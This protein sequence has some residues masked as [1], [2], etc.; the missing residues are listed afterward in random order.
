MMFSRYSFYD[1]SLQRSPEIDN[2][3]IF[4]PKRDHK[5]FHMFFRAPKPSGGKCPM[6]NA[7][8]ATFLR[9]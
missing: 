9:S 7:D 1:E 4:A 3:S 6:K 2:R 5:F 8:K